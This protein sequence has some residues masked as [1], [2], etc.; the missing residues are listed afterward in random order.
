MTKTFLLEISNDKELLGLL[1]GDEELVS[2]VEQPRSYGIDLAIFEAAGER[3][4]SSFTR[5]SNQIMLLGERIQAV[6]EH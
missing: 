3:F 1:K 6:R 2:T 4:V 5:F